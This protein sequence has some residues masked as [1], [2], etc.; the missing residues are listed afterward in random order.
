MSLISL[1]AACLLASYGNL[2]ASDLIYK[3]RN[4][5]FGGDS[6]NSSH[7]L[8]TANAQN[9]HED[10]S[11][12]LNDP[13]QSFEETITRS[14]LNRISLEIADQILGEDAAQSGQ[15]VVGDTVLRFNRQDGSVIINI[16]DGITGQSTTLE[17]PT[18]G[19]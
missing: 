12:S 4:P 15:F 16:T 13:L 11:A 2:M 3:P 10:D 1:S 7:L 8:G 14:L 9:N 19:L 6:F 17:V 18:A 5:S